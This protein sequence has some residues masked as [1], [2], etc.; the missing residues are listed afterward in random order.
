MVRSR[1]LREAV[2]RALA[3]AAAMPPAK[4][5][6][7]APGSDTVH[8]PAAPLIRVLVA[9]DN[10]VN[11]MVAVRLLERLG[12]R[13]DV[14][15]NGAEAVQMAT[16]LPYH[17][18]FMDC[19]MPEMDGFDATAEIRRRETEVG[20]PP[21]PIVAVTASVLQEDR[22]RC[23]SAGMNDIIGKPV[24]PAQLAQALRRFAP[25]DTGATRS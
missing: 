24:L 19:H 20:R 16:R 22:D 17:L 15:G 9:E 21:M 18:I 25:K 5:T 2:C 13:V 8:A 6:A 3:H 14:A 23:V 11:Q 12:C 7:A 1:L 4:L 10:S